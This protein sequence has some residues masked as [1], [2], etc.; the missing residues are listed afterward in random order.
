MYGRQSDVATES[1]IF[2]YTKILYDGLNLVKCICKFIVNIEIVN[3]KRAK[4]S[5]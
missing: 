1:I 2:G 3:A 5:L 4:A